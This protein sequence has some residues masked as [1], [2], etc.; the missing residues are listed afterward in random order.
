MENSFPH[1]YH[2]DPLDHSRL[3]RNPIRGQSLLSESQSKEDSRQ[4][5]LVEALALDQRDATDAAVERAQYG[6]TGETFEEPLVID[7]EK[8]MEE[9]MENLVKEFGPWTDNT[10]KFIQQ[11]P[12]EWSSEV[13]LGLKY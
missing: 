10:E 2:D 13:R 5:K 8:T 11:I 3:H 6:A 4:A 12:G 7:S 9:R 1:I